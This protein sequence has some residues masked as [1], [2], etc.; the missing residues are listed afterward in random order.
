MLG[1]SDVVLKQWLKNKER[2]ADLFNAV[3]FNGEQVIKPEELEEIN[4]ESGIVIASAIAVKIINLTFFG[5]ACI[6]FCSFRKN[7]IKYS[8]PFILQKHN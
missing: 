1:K 6:V 7:F 4:G 3:V 5:F 8:I 2:F